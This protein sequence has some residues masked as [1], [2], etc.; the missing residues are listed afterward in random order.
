MFLSI[1]LSSGTQFVTAKKYPQT[2][3]ERTK[4]LMRVPIIRHHSSSFN[5]LNRQR[6]QHVT[7]DFSP[8]H[9]PSSTPP[10]SSSTQELAF[11]KAVDM[12]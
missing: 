5:F 6:N 1:P 11:D 2:R 9:L 3:V 8:L 7:D 4:L 12:F 10:P